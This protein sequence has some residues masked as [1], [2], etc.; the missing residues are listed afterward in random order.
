MLL[1][2]S[3]HN[4]RVVGVREHF[5]PGNTGLKLDRSPREDGSGCDV[6]RLTTI[7]DMLRYR[8]EGPE[9]VIIHCCYSTPR[10]GGRTK[11]HDR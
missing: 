9:N 2:V 5:L 4:D 8:R 7:H 10:Q 1:T 3:H 11:S 6:S